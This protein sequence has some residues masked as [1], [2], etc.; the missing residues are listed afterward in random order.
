MF[1]VVTFAELFVVIN[2][3]VLCIVDGMACSQKRANRPRII[4]SSEFCLTTEN[5]ITLVTL[6]FASWLSSVAGRLMVP[7]NH[8]LCPVKLTSGARVGGIRILFQDGGS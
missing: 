2:C 8:N 3:I 5:S 7:S 1:R 6:S 4:S